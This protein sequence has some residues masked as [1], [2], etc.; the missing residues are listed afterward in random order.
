MAKRIVIVDDDRD[1][2]DLLRTPLEFAGHEV[3]TA[4]DGLEGT[5]LVYQANPDLLILDV[6]MPKMSGYQICK[7]LRSTP[8][9]KDLPIILLTAKARPQDAAWGEK[10]GCTEYITKPFILNDV[11]RTV[12]RLLASTQ[13]QERPPIQLAKDDAQWVD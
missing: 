7:G 8:H 11:I 1:I 3:L 12:E 4:K 2:V 13:K 9:F 5:N 10:M 6:M